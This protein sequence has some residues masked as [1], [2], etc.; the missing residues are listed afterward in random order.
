M[1]E[2]KNPEDLKKLLQT[3]EPIVIFYFLRSC[4]HCQVMHEPYA[5]LEKKNKKKAF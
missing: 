4:G 5:E 1:K 2:I 3:D